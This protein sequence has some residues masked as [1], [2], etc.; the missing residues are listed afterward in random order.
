MCLCA[1]VSVSTDGV[2]VCLCVC[3]CVPRL[4]L[5]VCLSPGPRP[6]P[7]LTNS[8]SNLPTGAQ[9]RSWGKEVCFLQ[10]EERGQRKAL[11]PGAHRALPGIRTSCLHSVSGH[12]FWGP[13]VGGIMPFLW[14]LASLNIT[15]SS[16]TPVAAR[17]EHRSSQGPDKASLCT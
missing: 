12:L 6:P 16:L 9:G 7:S 4:S 2:C 8:S 10:S 1:S 15:S 14:G 3:L 11:C 13:P 17:R 5:T